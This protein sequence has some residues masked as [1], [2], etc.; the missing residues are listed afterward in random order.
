[1]SRAKEIHKTVKKNSIPGQTGINEKIWLA[2]ILIFITL[3]YS[4]SFHNGILNFDDIEYFTLYPEVLK[5]NWS[6]L[7]LYF[8]KHYVLM[9]QPLPVLTFA[10]NNAIS[11]LNTFPMHIINLLFHMGNV[12][13]LYR[14]IYLLRENKS[15]AL[16]VA[17]LFGIHPMNVEAV[18]WISARSSG[19]YVFFF[20]IGI[21]YY[22]MYLKQQFPVKYLLLAGIFFL[23]SLFSKAQA[24]TFPLV[25]VML[26]Y[27]Y[28]RKLLSKRVILEKLPFLI[29]SIVFGIV[30]LADKGTQQ[31]LTNGMMINYSYFDML[32]L[33]TWSFSFYVIKFIF[34][35][36][37]C[38]V[39]VYPLKVNEMLPIEYYFSAALILGLIYLIYRNKRHRWLVFGVGFFIAVISINIQLIPSRLFIVTDRYGYLPYVGIFIMAIFMVDHWKKMNSMSFRKYSIWLWGGLT[40]YC[41]IFSIEVIGRNR[42]WANDLTLM[43]DIISK[44]PEVPY[45][46]RA[47]GIRGLYKVNNGN[48]IDGIN[49][50][51][52][53]IEIFPSDGKTYMNRAIAYSR[54]NNNAAAIADLNESAKR[55]P[56]QPQIFSY[57]AILIYQM[58][59]K[60]QAWKDCNR[61]LELDAKFV[62]CY[63]TRGTVAFDRLDYNQSIS[64]FTKAIELQPTS[65]VPYKNR[66]QVYIQ[67]NKNYEACKDFQKAAEMGNS[68]AI[69]L[70]QIHCN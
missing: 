55:S 65:S 61:C 46:Y 47:Y 51:T 45:L 36:N 24:V 43:D 4:N 54:M 25:L 7:M 33:V 70:Q 38:S 37:L 29:L 1:M 9:Y 56:E 42:A 58:G 18:S 52:K 5:L 15:E 22:L 28:E 10:M 3:I 67:M 17:F 59:N 16:L 49:D 20:L 8:S 19:M 11:G 64:D 53:A 50:F 63:I 30:A 26:D 57:R 69:Q 62:D 6:N 2:L 35:V 66:G 44:N 21:N 40:I 39:Y 60:E 31:N 41:I 27:F 23:L 34:P 13:L 48:P 14:F 12:C 32:F 68:D